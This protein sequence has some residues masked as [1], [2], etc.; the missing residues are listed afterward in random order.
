MAVELNYYDETGIRHELYRDGDGFW[1]SQPS[2]YPIHYETTFTATGSLDTSLTLQMNGDVGDWFQVDNVRLYGTDNITDTY[3][4]NIGESNDAELSGNPQGYREISE[5]PN[6]LN[7]LLVPVNEYI[8]HSSFNAI[9][10]KMQEN[11]EFLIDKAEF[12]SVP[13]NDVSFRYGPSSYEY[14]DGNSAVWTQFGNGSSQ[15]WDYSSSMNIDHV[16]GTSMNMIYS[17]DNVLK[18]SSVLSGANPTESGR[19]FYVYGDDTFTDIKSIEIDSNDFIWVLD[20]AGTHGR[21]GIF[22]FDNIWKFQSIWDVTTEGNPKHIIN[23]TDLKIQDGNVYISCDKIG[24]GCE[25][26]IFTEVGSHKGSISHGELVNIESI[27][28]TSEYIIALYDNKLF[29]FNI[30]HEF[31]NIIDLTGDIVT[32]T[33]EGASYIPATITRLSNDNNGIFFYGIAGNLIYKFSQSGVIIESFGEIMVNFINST[34]DDDTIYLK[35]ISDIHH[36]SEYNLYAASE[37]DIVKY[38]DRAEI[39]NRLLENEQFNII[40]NV[41]TLTEL[42]SSSDENTTAWVYNRIFDRIFDN[43]NIFR[44]SLKGSQALIAGS[45]FEEV[46]INN[47]APTQYI[48]LPWDKDQIVI[49]VNELHCEG[50][51]N[52]CILQLQD[53]FNTCLD[54]INIKGS[55]IDSD[56]LRILS[57]E[58]IS[59]NPNSP[60]V[61]FIDGTYYYDYGRT[62]R[63]FAFKWLDTVTYRGDPSLEAFITQGASMTEI[64]LPTDPVPITFIDPMIKDVGEHSWTL[65]ETYDIL[66][67]T[68]TIAVKWSKRLFAGTIPDSVDLS[69]SIGSELV[70]PVNLQWDSL[71]PNLTGDISIDITD[72][73]RYYIAI[74]TAENGTNI[75]VYHPDYPDFEYEWDGMSKVTIPNFDGGFGDIGSYD[76]LTCIKIVGEDIYTSGIDEIKFK[77]ERQ[78]P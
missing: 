7:T 12:L 8:T 56:A 71:T 47:F 39:F 26:R 19:A 78:T 72:G 18:A 64:A 5:F 58:L 9:L 66:E 27:A 68:A 76:V 65:R 6:N 30:D 46:V 45:G 2:P 54:Y 35:P 60:L 33:Y 62:V 34:I 29:R 50:T 21:V 55:G 36:D 14:W 32:Y 67:D 44:L 17:T 75:H 16:A 53:C 59:Q 51:L 57:F 10:G 4:I 70:D 28:V 15:Y 52:R 24:G 77:I 73:Y 74:P 38:F 1:Q 13:P 20:D 69:T 25:I 37:Y 48:P 22:D 49:G 31:I 23:P 11:Y 61:E 3:N 63:D 42:D 40:D 41:W 43:L